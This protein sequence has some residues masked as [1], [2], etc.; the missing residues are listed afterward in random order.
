MGNL[1]IFKKYKNFRK[2]NQITPLNGNFHSQNRLRFQLHYLFIRSRV[3]E[4]IRTSEFIQI[5]VTQIESSYL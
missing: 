3:V 2:T 5:S 1:I 4:V